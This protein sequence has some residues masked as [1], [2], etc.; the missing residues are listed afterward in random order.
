MGVRDATNMVG[1][2]ECQYTH[3]VIK[4][5]INIIQYTQTSYNSTFTPM[6]SV[7]LFFLLI[8][9]SS[10]LSHS[11]NPPRLKLGDKM[12]KTMFV[13]NGLLENFQ[14]FLILSFTIPVALPLY[15]Y[16]LM[17]IL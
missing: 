4:K 5:S 12:R 14:T 13:L 2:G 9:C 17:I 6:R 8:L 11:L 15:S 1:E 16:T 3:D 7:F 10:Y